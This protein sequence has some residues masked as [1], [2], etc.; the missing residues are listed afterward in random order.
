MKIPLVK[1]HDIK[2]DTEVINHAVIAK[3]NMN[4]LSKDINF[5]KSSMSFLYF[6]CC[7]L[8]GTI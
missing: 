3:I 7:L 6:L 4:Y 1:L 2:Q 8:K 5:D